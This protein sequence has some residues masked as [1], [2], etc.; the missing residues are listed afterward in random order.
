M[1][2]DSEVVAVAA[3]NK[4][5]TLTS[6]LASAGCALLAGLPTQTQAAE[7]DKWDIDTAALIYAEGDDRVMAFEPVI[8]ATRNFDSETK[9][10]LKLALDTLT[11]ASPNGATPSDQPQ[12]FARPSG[13]GTYT[14]AATEQPLDDT[15]RDT[16]AAFSATW[17]APLNRDWAYS[18]GGYLS[19][20]HDYQSVGVNGSLSRYLNQKNTTLTLGINLSS[21]SINPEGGV[22]VGMSRMANPGSGSYDTDFDNSRDG[23]SETKQIFDIIAG[24][25]QVI[26]RNTLMQF[27]YSL[28]SSS[29]Y[30]TDPYKIV[31]VIDDAAGANFGGNLA[32]GNG[33]IYVYEERPDTR[34]KHALYWQGKRQL[35][36]GDIA[37]I[38]YRFMTDDWGINSHTL[39]F[40][41]RWDLGQSYLEPQVRWYSQSAADFYERYLTASNYQTQEAVSADYRLGEMDA[42]TLGIKYGHR[43]SGDREWYGRLA[44]YQ[45]T[46]SGDNGFGKLQ[47]QELY[48]ETTATMLTFG[49]RF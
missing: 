22:P 37:D 12:T 19:S 35:S 2:V 44:F 8:S 32:D 11:G 20:E 46:N 33:N 47:T 31:S 5:K 7:L 3:I 16:R 36:N 21:D 24:V 48:P 25:T 29:G 9:L 4:D 18:A 14:T 38:S 23:S 43:L 13:N 42:W 6:I 27:N 30:L 41:Y 39:E 40:R 1:A 49:Y 28:S 10:N 34:L 17:S 45:Q 26:D 15:F